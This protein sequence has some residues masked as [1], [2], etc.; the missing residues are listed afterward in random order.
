[1]SAEGYR[2][3]KPRCWCFRILLLAF[4]LAAIAGAAAYYFRAPLLIRLAQAWI[5]DEPPRKA[6]AILV[7]GGGVGWRPM[8]AARLYT[9]GY[10]P[11][12]LVINVQPDTAVEL[13][14]APTEQ[15]LVSAVLESKGVPKEAIVPLGNSSSSTYEDLRAA[16]DWAKSTNATRILIPTDL[17]H[18][19]R[20]SWTADRLLG[21]AGVESQILPFALPE[22]TLTNWWNTEKGLVDFNNEAIKFVFYL[23]K[24]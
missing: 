22:Y 2:R 23:K 6:D 24:Y 4:L 12:I 14:I 20:V 17:F 21:E 11:K 5:V 19:R 10:A 1:M 9:N 3:E 18:T 15:E 16:S 7:L 13:G 8:E